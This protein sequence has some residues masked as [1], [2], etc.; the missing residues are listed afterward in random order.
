M[1][2]LLDF[3]KRYKATPPHAFVYCQSLNPRA[4]LYAHFHYELNKTLPTLS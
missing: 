4:N 1:K 2:S 3:L